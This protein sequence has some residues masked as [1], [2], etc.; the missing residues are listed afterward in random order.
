M[1]P[2]PAPV[3]L[4]GLLAL[5][6]CSTSARDVRREGEPHSPWIQPTPLLAQQIEDEAKRL[7]YTHGFERLEQIRWFA[8]IGEPAYPFLLRLAADPRDDVAAAALASLGATLDARLVPH[9]HALAWSEERV[10]GD[11]GLERAR[12]LVRL[13]D[14]S[15]LP[16][17]IAGLRDERT[18]TRSLCLDALREATHETHD[19]DPRSEASVRELAVRAWEQW[20]QQRSGEG[21]LPAR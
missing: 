13:G 6:A 7:P 17:L 19:Y 15:E 8:S 10:S 1:N 4:L 11:L 5:G 21:I 2:S 14:W 16:R 3:L 12:T 9:V 18:F 20:W